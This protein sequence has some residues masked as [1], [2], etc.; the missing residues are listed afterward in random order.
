LLRGWFGQNAGLPGTDYRVVFTRRAGHWSIRPLSGIVEIT[1]A[2]SAAESL[3]L[4]NASTIKPTSAPTNE[5]AI[6]STI[7]A[8]IEL[9]IEL[10]VARRAQYTTH[11]PVHDL[12]AA[13]GSWGPDGVPNEIGWI[14]VRGQRLSKGMFAAR[15]IGESMEPKI[16]S[17]SWCLFR[18][19][20]AGTK[21][22][23][24]LLVQLNSFT[25]PID[26]GRYTVK[27][28]RSEIESV[29]DSWQHKSITLVP[30][31]PAFDPIHIS[32]NDAPDLRIIGEFVCV[33]DL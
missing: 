30:L 4:P 32:P 25:D 9:S 2:P 33:I 8:T 29:E 16:P 21:Q 20:P 23:R 7:E 12:V 6:E 13:A 17:G 14:K 27:K 1:P 26:G 31:N 15:V 3:T 18:P 28:Y 24:L 19:C 11:V 5:P 10:T 22:N